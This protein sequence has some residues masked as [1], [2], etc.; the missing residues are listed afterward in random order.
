MRD[1]ANKK[2]PESEGRKPSVQFEES[3]RRSATWRWTVMQ[4]S[5]RTWIS[6]KMNTQQLRGIDEFT[7]LLQDIEEEQKEK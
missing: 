3:V 2:L 1:K 7:D 4:T 5:V 6:E